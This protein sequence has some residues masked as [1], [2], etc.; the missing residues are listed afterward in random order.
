MTRTCRNCACFA[1]QKP[2]G[3]IMPPDDEEYMGICRRMTP[4]GRFARVELPVLK[5]GEPVLNRAG[6]PQ[7]EVRNVLQIGYPPVIPEAV[8]FDGWRPEGTEPGARWPWAIPKHE[9]DSERV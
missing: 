7:L 8:C 2:D 4:G 3:T 9:T 5:D 1:R 6:K